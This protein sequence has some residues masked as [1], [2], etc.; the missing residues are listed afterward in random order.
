L[1]VGLLY[2]WSKVQRRTRYVTIFGHGHGCRR[3]SIYSN[4]CSF[5][6]PN[7]LIGSQT[8]FNTTLGTYIWKI[9]KTIII[10]GFSMILKN[11]VGLYLDN[12]VVRA[13]LVVRYWV[14]LCQVGF[15]IHKFY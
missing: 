13:E 8:A 6:T 12:F 7:Q 11:Y 14:G 10:M 3:H 2:C 15:W 4:N 5:P 1:Q 9:H